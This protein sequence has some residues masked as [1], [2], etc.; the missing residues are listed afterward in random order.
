MFYQQAINTLDLIDNVIKKSIE[1]VTEEGSKK[2]SSEVAEKLEVS[3]KETHEQLSKSYLSYSKEIR[4]CGPPSTMNLIT[5]QY[6][7]SC[8]DLNS[9]F[10]MVAAKMLGDI[11]KKEEVEQLKIEISALKVEKK[12][13]LRENEQLRDQI[14]VKDVEEQKNITLMEKLNE[15]NRN[16]H[17]WLTTALENSK[18]LGAV[19]EDGNRRVKEKEERIKE[20]ENRKTEQLE[21]KNEELAKKDE[22]IKELKEWSDQATERIE[23]LEKKEEELNKMIE[24]SKEKD[25]P[26]IEE[27]NKELTRLKDEMALKELEN[28]KILAGRDEK[29]DWKDKEMEKLRKTIAY[30]ERES[31]EWKEKESDL[32]RGLGTIKKMILE[33]EEDRKMKDGL[34]TNLVK[35]LAESKEKLKRLH[36]ALVSSKQKLEEMSGRSDN[37]GFVELN[38]SKENMDKIR[39]EIE[40]NCRES[41]FDHLEEQDE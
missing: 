21:R 15:E 41:S 4:L 19:V 2:C 24:E 36:G 11:E 35:E 16:L 6:A 9:K 17:K 31:D 8:M 38:E 29:L 28:R 30:Y 10:V 14:R 18:T 25:V 3:R 13:Q 39:E 40:K 5:H 22:K 20:L 27:L 12:E 32:L 37:S 7:Q 33:G 1:S 34:L 26:K 23:T